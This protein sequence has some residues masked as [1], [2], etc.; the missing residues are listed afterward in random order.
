MTEEKKP[1]EPLQSDAELAA[2]Q[3]PKID[4]PE[5]GVKPR[6][7]FPTLGDLFAMLGI[8]LGAQIIVGVV[9]VIV[10]SLSGVDTQTADPAARG[11][12]M[13]VTYLAAMS[14]ALA[15]VL[16]YR[17]IRGG[18]GSVARFSVRGLNPVVLVW[19]FVF[20]VA[21]GVVLDPLI[22][23][24]PKPPTE[25]LG[26]GLWTV[27]ALVVFAP[28]LEELL[29]RGVVLGAI[30]SRYGVVAAWLGSS[31]F[32]AILHFQPALVVNAFAMGL[33]LGYIYLATESLWA[34]MILH[35][36]NN[37]AAYVLMVSKYADMTLEQALGGHSVYVRVYVAAVAVT[38]GSGYMVWRSVRRMKERDKNHAQA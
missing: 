21:V 15:A 30:R 33:I 8:A 10:L 23:M 13:A 11:R 35:A 38:L 25:Q 37:A 24:F 2:Q 4:A 18:N 1:M 19:A 20:V 27:M 7:P 16:V 14:L 5:Q 22:S 6:K 9:G 17:R 34:A 31:L 12:V 28:V 36:A 26:R 3:T 32:F 29:C